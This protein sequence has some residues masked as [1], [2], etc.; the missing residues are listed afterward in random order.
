MRLA[1][2]LRRQSNAV[3]PTVLAVFIAGVLVASPASALQQGQSATAQAEVGPAQ[4]GIIDRVLVRVSGVAI[5]YSDFEL[6]LQE[7]IGTIAGQIPRDQLDAQMPMLRLNLMVGLVEAALLEQ[8]AAELGII[9]GPNDIDRAIM[10]IRENSG[11]MD[12]AMWSQA[13]AE[14]GLTEARMREQAAGAIVQ[15][16]MMFQEI[17]RQVFVSRREIQ[18]YYE[19]NPGTFTEPEEVLYQQ[20]VFAYQGA[21]RVPIRE[22]A[23]NALTELR[24]GISLTAV[25]S[26][27][28]TPNVDVIQDAASASWVAPEDIQEEIR[29]VVAALTPLSYSDVVE[30]R[31][32]YHI[33][34]LMDRREGRIIPLDEVSE[35]IRNQLTDQKMGVRLE[36]Y[37]SELIEKASLEI[38]AEEFVNLRDAWSEERRGAPTGPARQQR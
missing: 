4:G 27:Y 29:V 8:R 30:G 10:N 2:V 5:L 19:A 13:L 3:L 25:G 12:D 34:Q 35:W 1:A 33:L 26:K 9:A 22:R 38:Y 11:L 14:N 36:E 6:Q 18:T 7:Q 31:F 15:Q 17:Q 24:A 37:T 23:D 20:L 28:A 32:G 16:T 21:D